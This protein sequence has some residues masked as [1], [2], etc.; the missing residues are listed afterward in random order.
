MT[1]CQQKYLH[2]LSCLM[3]DSSFQHTE[4]VWGGGEAVTARHHSQLSGLSVSRSA[5]A[6]QEIFCSVPGHLAYFSSCSTFSCFPD[7][8]PS[9][10]YL[11][12]LPDGDTFSEF[13][14]LGFFPLVSVARGQ[15]L[16]I[17]LSL[18]G[19]DQVRESRAPCVHLQSPVLL[20][21]LLFHSDL[22]QM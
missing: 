1:L 2:F 22:R 18:R 17:K 5:V 7:S 10:T 15:V 9:S 16:E 8:F 19:A 11:S 12:I 14:V 4:V 13:C 20:K 3:L 6:L 21:L